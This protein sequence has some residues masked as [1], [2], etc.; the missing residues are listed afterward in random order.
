MSYAEINEEVMSLT[1]SDF[2]LRLSL[3]AEEKMLD[4]ID[5]HIMNRIELD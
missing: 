4:I 5:D 2:L 3:E 1:V